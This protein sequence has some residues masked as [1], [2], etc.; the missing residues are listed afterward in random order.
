MLKP[1]GNIFY[2]D[3]YDTIYRVEWK[4]I[5]GVVDI[6]SIMMQPY[7]WGKEPK[8]YV[9]N[10]LVFKFGIVTVERQVI[11]FLDSGY[12]IVADGVSQY[13]DYV[14]VNFPCGVGPVDNFKYHLDS[15][16]LD[17]VSCSML[18]GP[19]WADPDDSN[20]SDMIWGDLS[21]DGEVIDSVSAGVNNFEW[22]N[23][24]NI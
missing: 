9:S 17:D 4:T 20:D 11:K 5:G 14:Q 19:R 2:K 12:E 8:G 10:G 24:W 6:T 1:S 16:M 7:V 22:M 21:I 23:V 13:E 3:E 15:A 18:D